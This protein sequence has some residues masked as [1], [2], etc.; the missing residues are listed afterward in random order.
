MEIVS[1]Y[2]HNFLVFEDFKYNFVNNPVMV[3]GRNEDDLGQ[4]SNGTG[5]SSM[6]CLVEFGLTGNNSQK[7][8]ISE[9]VRFD[10]KKAEIGLVLHC[11]IRKESILI[12]R[13]IPA[14]GSAKI[15]I[16]RKIDGE[17]DFSTIESLGDNVAVNEKWLSD[18]VQ[19][20]TKD[21]LNF[22]LINEK[23]FKSFF[24]SN[25]SDKVSL[26]N[27]FSNADIIEGTEK[28]VDE[29]VKDLEGK[30]KEKVKTKNSL[31]GSIT[32][33]EKAI[34]ENQS[35]DFEK[36][37]A[38]RIK[39]IR[40]K[41][42]EGQQTIKS[43]KEAISTLEKEISDLKVEQGKIK[44]SLSDVQNLIDAKGENKKEAEIKK[45]SEKREK[46]D[47]EVQKLNS[48][49]DKERRE[50]NE[51]KT[52]I[53]DIDGILAGAITCPRCSHQFILGSE[54]VSIEDQKADKVLASEAQGEIEDSIKSIR[55]SLDGVSR[56]ISEMRLTEASLKE[57]SKA[58]EKEKRELNEKLD[59]IESQ[60]SMKARAIKQRELSIENLNDN[61]ASLA[62][63]SSSLLKR[64]DE[65][66]KE[67][68][69]SDSVVFAAKKR[70]EGYESDLA[71]TEK[72]ILSLENDLFETKQWITN[73]KR[74][75]FYLA[76]KPIKPIES[77]C[78]Y[79]LT[80]MKSDMR[81]KLEGF[82]MNA[83]GEIKEEITISV[84]RGFSRKF[85][86]FSKGERG[87]LEVAMILSLQSMINSNHAYGGLNF[88]M[89]D[90]IFD[91][92]DSLGIQNMVKSLNVF[93]FPILIVS[94]VVDRGV[95]SGKLIFV[96]QNGTTKILK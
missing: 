55:E 52:M 48:I 6:M 69:E 38:D 83:K 26:L 64:I 11:S 78:N 43:R 9:L 30:I 27:R 51:I 81:I 82:K 72:E 4:E 2:A 32:E 36:D 34:E 84:I 41:N 49:L 91:G 85:S 60:V 25:K 18:W 8:T 68:D 89:V 96:K 77:S 65:I 54:D 28:C 61:I 57:E 31:L 93:H 74:F 53:S 1:C 13:V 90:E 79:F 66:A 35:F 86:S 70:K 3:E 20:D 88:L 12:E 58:F 33:V 92:L 7:D 24:S 63:S 71:K 44:V 16:K 46:K 29:D 42:F 94:H 23:T 75:S 67:V 76:G 47:K 56:E 14:K 40:D 22:Y 21:L 50:L 19:I 45:A 80:Q 59:S 10:T 95:S 62:L 37:K 5:K 87:R 15:S 39:A 73:L 17:A